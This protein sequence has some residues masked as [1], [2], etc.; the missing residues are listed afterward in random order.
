M[1]KT[2]DRLPTPL[3]VFFNQYGYIS[4]PLL[5]FIALI[6]AL[7]A[8]GFN[9]VSLAI[10]VVVLLGLAAFWALTHARQ[11]P[12]AP[13]SKFALLDEIKSSG[14]YAMLAFE[15]EFCLSSTRV[16][17]QLNELEARYPKQFQVYS[18]SVLKEPGKDLFKTYRGRVTPTYVLL[19]EEGKVLMDW[20]LVLPV[21]RISYEVKR[22]S[23]EIAQ[24]SSR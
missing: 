8:Y 16:G 14:K 22:H 6:I 13:Q 12:N 23:Q 19:D 11:T 4:L 1:L 2:L 15:S 21:E 3:R 18:I 20:P 24:V 9:L 17:Q 10:L 5:P 7:V